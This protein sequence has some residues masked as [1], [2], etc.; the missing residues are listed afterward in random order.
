LRVDT[1][2][3]GPTTFTRNDGTVGASFEIVADS[4]R[5]IGGRERGAGEY[6]EEGAYSGASSSS[7]R[8]SS[9]AQEEDDIPF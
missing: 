3:G 8:G 9:A 7:S 4:V 1:T 2:T 6:S 5:F